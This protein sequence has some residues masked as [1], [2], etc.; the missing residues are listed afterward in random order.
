MAVC[1]AEIMSRVV[2]YLIVLSHLGF[3]VFVIAGGQLVQVWPTVAWLHLPCVAYGLF[4]MTVRWRC[5]LTDLEKQFRR[6]SGQEP[7]SGDFLNHYLWS[8][9]DRI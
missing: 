2:A 3:V 5:P 7:Y 4:I 1:G 8:R 9:L 6:W